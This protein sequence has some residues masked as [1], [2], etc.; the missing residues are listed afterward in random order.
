MRGGKQEK[1]TGGENEETQKDKEREGHGNALIP[2]ALKNFN[3]EVVTGS[4]I[5]PA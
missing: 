5:T 1:N 4:C 3:D 2:R